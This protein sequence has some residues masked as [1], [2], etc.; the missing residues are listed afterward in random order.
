MRGFII[1]TTPTVKVKVAELDFFLISKAEIDIKQKDYLIVKEADIDLENGYLST[2]LTQEE[3]LGFDVAGQ[4]EL[5]IKI[6]TFDGNVIASKAVILPLS[7]ILNT[8]VME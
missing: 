1:G 5:Q 8:E 2:K 4:A 6:K 3:T 7:K